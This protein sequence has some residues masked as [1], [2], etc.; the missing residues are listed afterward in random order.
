MFNFTFTTHIPK[1]ANRIFG[2]VMGLTLTLSLLSA[3]PAQADM[4]EVNP[5]CPNASV[6]SNIMNQIC[7]DC[8]L[9]SLKLFG[10]GSKPDGASDKLDLPA[11]MCT[12]ALG[13]PEF[14][15]PLGMWSPQN[16]NEV[17]TT[18]WCSPALGGMRLQD[19]FIG[20]GKNGASN[21]RT[22][23]APT[24]FYQYH[25]FSYPIMAML[26]MMLLPDCTSGYVDFDLMYMSE[27]DPMHNNDLLT[28]LL[29]PE[30]VIFS[31]PAAFAWC[32]ADCVMTT[33]DNQKEEFYGCAGCDGHLYPFTGNIN[34]Q[35]D[36]VAGSSLITQRTLASLHRKGLARRTIGDEAMCKPEFYPTIPRSQYKF[37]MMH[38]VPQASTSPDKNIMTPFIGDPSNPEDVK[39]NDTATLAGSAGDSAEPYNDCCH[40]M[41]MSTARWCT[42]VGGR[43]RPGKDTAYLY[44]IW[45]YRNCCVKSI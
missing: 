10:V 27:I 29:N 5:S 2:V 16:V 39:A 22:N 33:A 40:P 15:T 35:P 14:G 37:S 8:F 13:V 28:L 42:P 32:A 19:S 20:M 45:Q 31:T 1:I 43:T 34:P 18:P 21:S 17:V 24:A 6:F 25:Y 23:S 30:A 26:G 12:D 11:C 3:T 4:S 38:P 9:D 7:W 36:P 41:G 44:M